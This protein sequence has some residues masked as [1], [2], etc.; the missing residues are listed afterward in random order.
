MSTEGARRLARAVKARRAELEVTQYD[1][2]QAGGPSNTTLTKIEAG[3]LESLTRKTARNL[4]AALEWEPGS[5]KRVWAGG[6]PIPLLPGVRPESSAIL[7]KQI[8]DADL[9]PATREALLKVLNESA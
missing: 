9:E 5:A 7:R 2:W 8:L 1:V 4:D 3:H 6:E